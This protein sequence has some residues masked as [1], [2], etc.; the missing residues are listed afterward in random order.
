M[1]RLEITL[2][3]RDLVFRPD[4]MDKTVPHTCNGVSYSDS[5]RDGQIFLAVPLNHMIHE[6][7]FYC[8]PSG[9]VLM[10][11]QINLL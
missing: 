5:E 7:S 6:C 1:T 8:M 11:N 2:C 4:N 10:L 3:P 9:G